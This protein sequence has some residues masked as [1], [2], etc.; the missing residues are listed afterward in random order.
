MPLGPFRG[1][2]G[3]IFVPL[4]VLGRPG[5]SQ[6]TPQGDHLGSKVGFGT[7]MPTVVTFFWGHFLERLGSKSLKKRCGSHVEKH[8]AQ[9]AAM[10]VSG[11]PLQP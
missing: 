9:R 2:F 7:K 6:G 11:D 5:A 1:D 4:G 8:Y 3:V 10:E